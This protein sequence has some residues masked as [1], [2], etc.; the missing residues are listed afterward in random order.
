[1]TIFKVISPELSSPGKVNFLLEAASVVNS[2]LL[3]L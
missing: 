2:A 1:V 3:Q